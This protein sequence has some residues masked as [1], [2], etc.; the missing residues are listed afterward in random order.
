MLVKFSIKQSK[1]YDITYTGFP[2]LLNDRV[3]SEGISN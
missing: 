3:K 2:I 1:L